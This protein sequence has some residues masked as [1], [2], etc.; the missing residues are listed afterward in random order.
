MQDKHL[1]LFLGAV[2][3]LIGCR[4][5]KE[6]PSPALEPDYPT[7]NVP[8][9]FRAAWVATVANINWP[10]RPDLPVAEQKKEAIAL[11]DVLARNNFNAVILQVRPQADALYPS[12]L[13]PWSYYLTGMQ[14]Q[15]PQPFYDPLSFWIEEAHQRGLELHAWLNPY[16]AHHTTGGPI[17]EQSIVRQYPDL[18]VELE[19]G[20][21]WMKPTHPQTQAHSL[22]VTMDLVQRYDLDGIHFDDYFYPYPS[23]NNGKD[24][25]DQADYEAYRSAGGG[26][27]R[28]DWRRAAVDTFIQ[29]LYS[30][31][32]A[33]KPH[34][35]FGI[36]PFGIWRPGYP[37]SIQG[38]DQY[39]ALYA[40]AR[41]WLQKG[42]IDYWTP[43]L[44][45][46]I[47]QIPQ[48]FP[49][50]LNWWTKQNSL[51]RH[52]WPGMSIGRLQ[53]AAAIDETL[54]QI[55]VTRGM[56]SEAPGQVHWSIGPL[57]ARPALA[58]TL[59][60][61]VY[62]R[63]ALVPPSPWLDDQPPAPPAVD[64]VLQADSV[65]VSWT[66]QGEESAF[67]WVL[68]W[69][70]GDQQRQRILNQN[71][72]FV[73]LPLFALRR[74]VPDSPV[75]EVLPPAASVLEKLSGVT[76]RAVDRTGQE[77][78]PR[79]VALP[80]FSQQQAGPLASFY[81]DPAPQ[82]LTGFHTG[83]SVL[84][85][86]RQ[87]AL[88]GK[89]W[90]IATNI[91]GWLEDKPLD[92]LPGRLRGGIDAGQSGLTPLNASL[93]TWPVREAFAKK[94]IQTIVVDWQL[95]GTAWDTDLL[96]LYKVLRH[97]A[98]E[99]IAVLVV[100]RP[101][102]LGGELV[103][104]PLWP[105][106]DSLGGSLPLR[107]GM[108]T[109]ELVLY[110]NDVFD[111]DLALQTVSMA[112]W[113]PAMSWPET[114]LT[115]TSGRTD[116][117]QWTQ[118]ATQLGMRFFT[119]ADLDPGFAMLQPYRALILGQPGN[120]GKRRD[121]QA[122]LQQNGLPEAQW[123]RLHSPALQDSRWALQLVADGGEQVMTIRKALTAM[124]VLYRQYPDQFAWFAP[125][126]DPAP[127]TPGR[128]WSEIYEAW[129]RQIRAFQT[130]RLYYALYD[131]AAG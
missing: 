26:L 2:L 53:G 66:P 43:Q 94:G 52:L 44:Y 77:S 1:A 106:P 84:T 98:W 4:T 37:P 74:G 109:A 96:R 131:R 56:V 126:I 117:L 48:S 35:K 22:A 128:T 71:Q 50:L 32:K 65:L 19:N 124:E 55:M 67:R 123:V 21:W 16:R 11:L 75:P 103:E 119:L 20:Y 31:I 105:R 13:E 8:R 27:A 12:E 59:R 97:C 36:S 28:D 58:D 70:Y 82:P 118:V 95:D 107:Y 60:K 49:V 64:A 114:G 38:F 62:R 129:Q 24:F 42:W 93:P 83:W 40:D 89:D 115:W 122:L 17:S 85:R 113:D 78:A 108:T 100:D 80:A 72:R 79:R 87:A 47:N 39:A 76:L 30:R 101:N 33:E 23:Y 127:G 34:V 69:H 88:A 57:V 6:T 81:H 112:N 41:K 121:C 110:W 7:S 3:L 14:G 18:V 45:W 99:R 125:G 46:P 15:A 120:S 102:P 86:R 92:A 5:A 63:Q 91:P 61:S 90:A 29:Q 10:S 9:E 130:R 116:L 54:N 111:F 104:G 25:P 51:G 68:T 73:R